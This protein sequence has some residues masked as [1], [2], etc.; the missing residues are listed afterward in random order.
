MLRACCLQATC[1]NWGLWA[2]PCAT[3]G[4]C[5]RI[6]FARGLALLVVCA[7]CTEASMDAQYA[8]C[9]STCRTQQRYMLS[10]SGGHIFHGQSTGG[11]Q[12]RTRV[13]NHHASL[14]QV[15]AHNDQRPSWDNNWPHNPE[16]PWNGF[17][18][19]DQASTARTEVIATAIDVLSRFLV[20]GA[21]GS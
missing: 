5:R 2:P 6:G 14:W 21:S 3:S 12:Q 13:S 8:R 20:G 18:V 19:C 11:V 4:T 1:S 10:I 16:I 15:H 17:V 9:R 7:T